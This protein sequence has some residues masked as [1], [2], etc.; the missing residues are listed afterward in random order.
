MIFVTTGT[1]LPFPRLVS[2]MDDLAPRLGERIIAQI[3]PD[4]QP[5]PAL[6]I[7]DHLLP[8]RFESLIAEARVIVGHAG[9]GTIMAARRHGKPLILMA[10]R[11]DLGEHRNDHQLATLAALEGRPGLYP[12]NE[13][14]DLERLLRRSDLRPAEAVPGPGLERL[15]SFI[16]DWIRETA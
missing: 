13:P 15:T 9:I 1:Q 12:A 14:V 6:E 10:R 4:P 2:A 3:G 7:I 11:H 5:Y 8:A 16:A